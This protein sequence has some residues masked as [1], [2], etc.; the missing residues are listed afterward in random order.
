LPLPLVPL[1]LMPPL[2]SLLLLQVLA[3]YCKHVALP[4]EV[5]LLLR[6][7]ASFLMKPQLL[8]V[9]H[10]ATI[11]TAA[12]TFATAAVT[13][14]TAATAVATAAATIAIAATAVATP[15]TAIAATTATT[16]AA[17]PTIDTAAIAVVCPDSSSRF[18]DC[19]RSSF[20]TGSSTAIS[21][22][23]NIAS[24]RHRHFHCC[25][26][27]SLT[28][29]L[30]VSALLACCHRSGRKGVSVQCVDQVR[31]VTTNWKPLLR[32]S[33]LPL[34]LAL[35]AAS[36]VT[37]TSNSCCGCCFRHR[38]HHQQA[39]CCKVGEAAS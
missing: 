9:H 18:N 28:L 5:E 12:A 15:A 24:T 25:F 36:S 38:S 16:I 13:I 3:H 34:P 6:K 10:A 11:A 7:L 39:P 2:L 27:L 22:V 32:L 37:A 26:L 8:L 29:L 21:I 23:T 30:I 14:A 19:T 20:V 35:A 17:A 1:L 31:I 33:P 4:L